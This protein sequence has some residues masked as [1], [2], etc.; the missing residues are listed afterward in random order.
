[1]ITTRYFWMLMNEI[2]W[3]LVTCLYIERNYDILLYIVYDPFIDLST[4]FW[5]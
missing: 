4:R 3:I 2:L 1:M 5:G